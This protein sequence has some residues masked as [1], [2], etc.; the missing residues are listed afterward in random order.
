MC[1][2]SCI[3][4]V[5]C[6]IFVFQAEDDFKKQERNLQTK[7]QTNNLHLKKPLMFTKQV[8][9][10]T[11]WSRQRDH[12]FPIASRSV[13]VRSSF[14]SR[15]SL[16]RYSLV[17]RRPIEDRTR[18]KQ[19]TNERATNVNRDADEKLSAT[20]RFATVMAGRIPFCNHKTAYCP[21]P[22]F[23]RGRK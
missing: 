3:P 19:K 16:V 1:Q 18:N 6:C 12:S 14:V 8:I 4:G 23:C 13:L 15:S 21:S 10:H 20:R 11:I 22:Y 5:P 2:N 17:Y 7:S 9:Q